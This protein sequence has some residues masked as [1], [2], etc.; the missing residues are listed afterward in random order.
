MLFYGN[1]PSPS[2]LNTGAPGHLAENHERKALGEVLPGGLDGQTL[3]LV[4]TGL[5]RVIHS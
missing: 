5:L 2:S 4:A 3:Q 1:L